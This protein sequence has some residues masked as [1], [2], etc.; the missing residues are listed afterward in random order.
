MRKKI[1]LLYESEKGK[2]VCDMAS[3]VLSQIAVAFEHAFF[4]PMY[5]CRGA[6]IPDDI[7]DQCSDADAVLA[8]DSDMIALPVLADELICTSRIRE[9][10]YA[11]LIDNQSLMGTDRI[12]DAVVVQALSGQA[13]SLRAAASQ[14]YTLSAKYNMP[15]SQVPPSGRLAEDWQK[16]VDAADSIS[17]PFHARELLLP[18]AVPDMIY[19]P[20]RIGVVLC[21]PYAGNILAEAAAALCGAPGMCYD[22]YTGGQCGLYSPLKQPGDFTDPFGLLRAL[23]RLLQ[24]LRMEQETACLEAAVRNVLQEGWRT[25][26]ILSDGCR[27]TDAGY[28]IELVDNQVAVAGEWISRQ[29]K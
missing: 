3:A 10:R 4:M 16:A 18:Q 28:I 14:A 6:V 29:K 24:E 17:A 7:M 11:F 9:L 20:S 25:D 12:L 5:K 26:D 23:C 2:A 13:D 22:A 15:V 19:R 27:K 8:G 1:I 21:P